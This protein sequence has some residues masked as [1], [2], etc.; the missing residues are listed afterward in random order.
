[1]NEKETPRACINTQSQQQNIMIQ[2]AGLHHAL[3]STTTPPKYNQQ[4]GDHNIEHQ[5]GE[6][7]VLQDERLQQF[8][9]PEL[10][11]YL[12]CASPKKVFLG[13]I[14]TSQGGWGRVPPG[15]VFSRE[16]QRH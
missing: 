8:Q 14:R 6:M 1:M 9:I 2:T 15:R 11:R 16:Q 3:S 5:T 7:V 12:A 4:H 10:W 13:W